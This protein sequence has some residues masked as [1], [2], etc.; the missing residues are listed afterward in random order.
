MVGFNPE[1][2]QRGVLESLKNKVVSIQIPE[3]S[4][5][6]ERRYYSQRQLSH[7]TGLQLL[8]T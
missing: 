5:Q 8:E 4:S 2:L 1:F 6:W 7:S 3:I